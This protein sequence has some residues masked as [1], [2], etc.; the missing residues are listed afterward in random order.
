MLVG[1]LGGWPGAASGAIVTK[2]ATIDGVTSTSAPPGS[3]MNA[4]VTADVS[5]T[6]WRA[7]DV[8][9]GSQTSDC[10]DH[11]NQSSGSNRHVSFKVTAPGAPANYDVAFQPNDD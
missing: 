9:F 11:D 3:V 4:T 10:V 7:T 1:V 2:S 6:T 5:N 8:R